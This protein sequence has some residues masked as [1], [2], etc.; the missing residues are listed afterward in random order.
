M[1]LVRRGPR[2]GGTGPSESRSCIP[3]HARSSDSWGLLGARASVLHRAGSQVLNSAW[4][5]KALGKMAV[6]GFREQAR[7][8]GNSFTS[9]GH[10]LRL[11]EMLTTGVTVTH[12][13]LLSTYCVPGTVRGVG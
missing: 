6:L 8:S 13:H 2:P 1:A 5:S 10:K 9:L 3:R 11:Q 7:E 12:P 4:S